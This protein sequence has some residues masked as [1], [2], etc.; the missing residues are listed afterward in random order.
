[1]TLAAL[2]QPGHQVLASDLT[3]RI[4]QIARGDQRLQLDSTEFVQRRAFRDAVRYLEEI[5]VLAVRDGDVESLLSDGQVLWD[6]DRDAAAMC[7]VASPSVL[8][9]VTSVADF[10][11]EPIPSH[12]EGRS[13]RARQLL[14]RRI[15]DQPVVYLHDLTADEA[16]LAWRNRR[17]EADN[18]ARLTGCGVELRREGIALI[19]HPIQ[20]L[21]NTSFPGAN[22]VAQAALLWLTAM[23]E[24]L[25]RRTDQIVSSS[26]A[27]D[28]GTAERTIENGAATRLWQD[29]LTEY[30]ERLGKDARER[31]DYF[32]DR[33]AALLRRYR[34][35]DAGPTGVTVTAFASR[36]RAAPSLTD[37]GASAFD[38][39]VMF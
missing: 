33:V 27:D 19:D 21:S 32:A 25:E 24:S 36:F 14:N 4:A 7:M 20:P 30:A 26:E 34:L 3:A 38:Q 17:R 12:S 37:D 15:I 9:S 35:A 1:L 22:S 18:L 6:I 16:E 28:A 10:I 23:L 11:D 29:M 2:E 31:P 39:V 13:R 8:R 5:G